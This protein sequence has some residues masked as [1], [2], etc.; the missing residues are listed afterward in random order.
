MLNLFL[1]EVSSLKII[2]KFGNFF[3]SKLTMYMENCDYIFLLESFYENN[4]ILNL[5][6]FAL[7]NLTYNLYL[8]NFL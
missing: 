7:S 6:Q 4:C 8:K 3:L 1:T 5:L 2:D